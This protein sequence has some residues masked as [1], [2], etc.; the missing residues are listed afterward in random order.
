MVIETLTVVNL[1]YVAYYRVYDN[2]PLVRFEVL[3]PV[4]MKNAV[5]M[6]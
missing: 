2:L 1:F 3:T 6:R 4:T 5:P